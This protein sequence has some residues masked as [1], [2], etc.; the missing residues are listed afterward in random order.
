MLCLSPF[1]T[2][3]RLH[4]SCVPSI[5]SGIDTSPPHY[6]LQA[7]GLLTH[8][9]TPQPLTTSIHPFSP[10]LR[11]SICPWV[12]KLAHPRPHSPPPPYTPPITGPITSLLR[13]HPLGTPPIYSR[14]GTL[15]LATNPRHNEDPPESETSSSAS[16][17]LRAASALHPQ[18][19][20]IL[21]IPKHWHIWLQFFRGLSILPAVYWAIYCGCVMFKEA[22]DL[23]A[24]GMPASVWKFE[25]RIWFTEV[26]LAILWVIFTLLLYV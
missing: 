14:Q 1:R 7:L 8:L 20:V 19:A 11:G 5:W 10:L 24:S 16:P 6:Q 22:L 17:P 9:L 4:G 2:L 26:F 13:E 21:N 25:Q 3:L 12:S 23:Y 18:V 15:S